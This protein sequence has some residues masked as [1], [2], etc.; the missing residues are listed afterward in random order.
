MSKIR[1]ALVIFW[2]SMA[3]IVATVL[4]LG[5]LQWQLA[6]EANP[7]SVGA[8]PDFSSSPSASAPPTVAASPTPDASASGE[9][10]SAEASGAPTPSGSS[11]SGGGSAATDEPQMVAA[12]MRVRIPA[13]G[14][15]T[16]VFPVGLDKN[17]AIEIPEDIRYVGWYEYG[18]PPGVDRGSAVLV[19][20]RD[21]VVQG[22]GVFYDLGSLSPGDKVYVKTSSGEELPYKV[23][24]REFIKKKSLPY[25]EL[26]AV[27]GKPRLTLI[28]CGGYYDKNNGGYQDNVVVT[29][30]PMFTPIST[31][32]TEESASPGSTSSPAPEPSAS[33]AAAEA[34]PAT[35]I[36][37]EAATVEVESSPIP[38]G[39]VTVR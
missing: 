8:R 4:Y 9:L 3:V 22:H 6:E 5:V 26:F 31:E 34:Q 32:P 30:V 20:H 1:P 35:V 36:A 7:D 11:T 21:G 27:D 14:V 29:A 23:V 2:A 13:M 17:R 10:P 12:P 37:P 16:K 25:K 24:S 19:A 28:S 15:N 18:V 33:A 38:L 39:G